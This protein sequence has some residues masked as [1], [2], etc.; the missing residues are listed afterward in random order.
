MSLGNYDDELVMIH[1]SLK[2]NILTRSE[3]WELN[4]NKIRPLEI[5]NRVISI[6]NNKKIANSHKLLFS[7]IELV[8]LNEDVNGYA[9][10]FYLE[11]GSGFKGEF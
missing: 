11:D 6:L 2:I 3:L 5:A 8:I 1:G 9:L 4:G 10:T 7:D